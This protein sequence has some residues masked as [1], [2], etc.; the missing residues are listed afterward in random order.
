MYGFAMRIIEAGLGGQ[1]QQNISFLRLSLYSLVF[2][3]FSALMWV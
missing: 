1:K 2:L 3:G